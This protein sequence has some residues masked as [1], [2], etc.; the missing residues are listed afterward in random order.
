MLS[1][2]VCVCLYVCDIFILHLLMACCYWPEIQYHPI[3]SHIE[4]THNIIMR[5]L[6]RFIGRLSF[7]SISRIHTHPSNM[8]MLLMTR[9]GKGQ[10]VGIIS[11]LVDTKRSI[12]DPWNCVFYLMNI[13]RQPKSLARR[14]RW[15]LRVLSSDMKEKFSSQLHNLR[16]RWVKEKWES[17]KLEI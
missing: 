11:K 5:L 1:F 13:L 16:Q 15:R 4:W 17:F 12:F 10:Q 2:H 6:P 14:I 9:H 3:N 8:R 7:D